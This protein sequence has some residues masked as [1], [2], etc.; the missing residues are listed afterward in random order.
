M[1]LGFPLPHVM[2]LKAAQQPWE[3]SVT[4]ADQTRM[5]KR[6]DTLGHAA[7]VAAPGGAGQVPGVIEEVKPKA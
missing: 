2:Q 7:A 6:A 5:V 4:W 1:Q 3:A